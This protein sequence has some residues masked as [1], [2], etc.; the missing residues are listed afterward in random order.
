MERQLVT[1][2]QAGDRGAFDLLV[3]E[4]VDRLYS[5]AYRILRHGPSAEDA[6]QQAL[7]AIWRHLPSLRDPDRC[8]P[9]TPS[10]AIADGRRPRV[11]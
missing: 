4:V 6:T 10:I 3:A 11:P 7:V 9:R 5:I 1:R 8:A 2:A